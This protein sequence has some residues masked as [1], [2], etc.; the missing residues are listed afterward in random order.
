M[1]FCKNNPMT[2]LPAI[3]FA[4]GLGSALSLTSAKDA[5]Y[6]LKDDSPSGMSVEKGELVVRMP[7]DPIALPK[8]KRISLI[9][10]KGSHEGDFVIQVDLAAAP[11]KG[12][13]PVIV[14]G[15][16]TLVEGVMVGGSD[17]AGY[18]ITL[19]S[20]DLASAR[21]W[22]KRLQELFGLPDSQVVDHAKVEPGTPK[23]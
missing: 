4:I 20:N 9:E 5:I 18:T 23:K 19:G 2:R 21:G 17:E 14:L 12:L 3:L 1:T 8:A 10:S 15:E 6:S 22:L 11:P 13:R 7:L 16:R